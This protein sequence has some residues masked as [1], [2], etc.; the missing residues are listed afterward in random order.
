MQERHLLYNNSPGEDISSIRTR[1]SISPEESA[2]LHQSHVLLTHALVSLSHFSRLLDDG[3]YSFDSR[4]LDA[5]H[6]LFR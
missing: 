1:W 5:A 6:C 4:P 2:R 3:G